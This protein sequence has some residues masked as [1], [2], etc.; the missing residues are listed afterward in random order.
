M[1]TQQSCSRI[2]AIHAA[3]TPEGRGGGPCCHCT[4]SPGPSTGRAHSR[5]WRRGSGQKRPGARLGLRCPPRGLGGDVH[6]L[7]SPAPCRSP[8]RLP[9]PWPGKMFLSFPQLPLPGSLWDQFSLYLCRL[10]SPFVRCVAVVGPRDGPT[11]LPQN[12]M[13]GR[14]ELS[15]VHGKTQ[16]APDPSSLGRGRG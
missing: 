9:D 6:T 11:L 4:L 10:G 12:V 5:S 15:H 2:V 16:K 7:V 14:E 8:L 3:N 1:K 13:E